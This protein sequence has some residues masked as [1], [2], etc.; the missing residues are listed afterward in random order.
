MLPLIAFLPIL[1]TL[2]LMLVF[3]WSAKWCLLISWIMAAV[4]GFLFWDIDVMSLM[5]SSVYGI[6]SAMD[7]L[8][9]ILGAILLMNTLKASGATAAINRGFTNI[10]PDKRVICLTLSVD[11][12]FGSIMDYFEIFMGRMLLCRKA[13]EKLGLSFKLNINGQALI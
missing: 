13:A 7:V 11:T 2:I 1:T 6:L 10:S 3:H 9:I 4:F 12:D 5:A 8:I